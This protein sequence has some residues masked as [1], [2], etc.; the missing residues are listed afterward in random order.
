M[1]INGY[2]VTCENLDNETLHNTMIKIAI[3]R[4]AMLLKINELSSIMKITNPE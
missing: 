2:G 4:D 3:D 1:E